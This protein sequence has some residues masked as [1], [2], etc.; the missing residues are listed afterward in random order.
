M[1]ERTLKYSNRTFRTRPDKLLFGPAG[2]RL[3]VDYL[4]KLPGFSGRIDYLHKVNLNLIFKVT[5]VKTA[6][7]ID[8]IQNLV[9]IL[10]SGKALL[11]R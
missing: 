7:R 8:T 11:G 9:T 6:K 4:D 2:N 1:S 3:F 5:T 10:A